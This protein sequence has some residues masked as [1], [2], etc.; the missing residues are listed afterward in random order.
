MPVMNTVNEVPDNNRVMALR[1]KHEELSRKVDV[2]QKDV[3]S[4]DHYVN[5]LKK[6]KLLVKEKLFL[7]E[8]QLIRA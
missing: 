3:L 2:A 4:S 1:Q 5:Q 6:E 8:K 7:E